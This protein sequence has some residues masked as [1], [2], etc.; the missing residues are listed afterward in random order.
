[1]SQDT[2]AFVS[3]CSICARSKASH[4]PPAG[5]LRPLPIPSRPWSHIAVDFVTGLPPSAGN[6]VIFTIV[7]R[8][9]KTVH[10][11]PLPKLPSASETADLMVQHVY[12]LHGI[13]QDIVSD[14]GP[15]FTSQVW[16]AFCKALGTSS[17]LSS[18]YHPQTNGQTELTN[19]DLE[20]AL[21]CVT[22][23]HP[24]SWVSQLPWVEYAHNSLTSAAT[25]M[26]PFMASL[27]YQPPLF[28]IQEEEVAVPSVQANLRRCRR[29]W[30]AVRSALLRSA[31]R[32]KRLADRHRTPAP[33]YQPGQKVW[34]SSRDL[35]LMVESRKLAPRFVGPFVIEKLINPSAVKLKLPPALNINPTF[36]VSLLK[37]VSTSSLCP[38]A[39]PPPP[40]RVIDDHPAY[41]VRRILDVR[42]RGFQF[43]VDWE[44]Y[45]PEE[46]SW[47]PRR[48]ILD[49]ALLKDFY[50][51]HPEKTGRAP[52]G[53][54]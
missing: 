34:L 33:T 39:D 49:K 48:F 4:Q 35:P 3:A 46:R 12:R 51:E 32:N 14:R 7:D 11:V 42:G 21:R 44:G 5:L 50:R 43:L 27:G 40:P 47:I 29:V 28:P 18:G 25:G 38:P 31:A 26:S 45:G 10:F 20:T 16:K 13:P 41:T 36:H 52:G 22:A 6:T 17:S 23:R 54:H 24:S 15:Q 8:F 9:S 37:P 30:R 19:Q 1:M 53:A 2:R